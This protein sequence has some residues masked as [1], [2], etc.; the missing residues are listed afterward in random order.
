MSEQL[1]CPCESIQH[2]WLTANPPGREYISYRPGDFVTFRHA[3]LR[4]RAGEIQLA[5][6]V[7]TARSDLGLQMLEWWAYIADVLTF[8]T[9]TQAN[10]F[11]LGTAD[12]EASVRGLIRLLGHRPRPGIGAKVMLAALSSNTRPFV[13][14]AGFQ[15][16][17]KPGPGKQPQVFELDADAP[18]DPTDAVQ[19]DAD[20]NGELFQGTNI[21]LQGS[22]SGLAVGERL[23]LLPRNWQTTTTGAATVTVGS[24][25][26]VKDACGRTKTRITL[27]ALPAATDVP[28]DSSAASYRLL[29]SYA[30]SGLWTYAANANAV[31]DATVCHLASLA[32]NIRASDPMFFD[33]PNFSHIRKVTEVEEQVWYANAAAATPGNPPSSPPVP[34]P[35][36]HTKLTFAPSV[37]ANA[38]QSARNSVQVHFDWRDVGDLV[39]A[40]TETPPISMPSIDALA[41]GNDLFPVMNKDVLIED[42]T[43]I[44]VKARG[45]V[46]DASREVIRLSAFSPT[47]PALQEPLRV[48]FNTL[49]L[50]CGKTVANEVLGS[51]DASIAGQ[52]FV[53]QKSPLTYLPDTDSPS[54]QGYR[55]TLRIWVDELEWTEAP[56]FYEQPASA[57]IFVTFEDEDAKTHVLFGD[58]INGA[59]L[60]TGRDNVVASYRFG[61]GHDAPEHGSLSVVLKPYPGLKSVRN[62]TRPSG[63][64]DPEPATRIAYYGPRSTLT[65]GRAISADDCTAIALETPGVTGARAYAVWDSA[66]QRALTTIY[67]AE[68]DAAREAVA[69]A[70]RKAMD[71]NRALDV[72]VA[73]PRRLSLSLTI[74]PAPDRK[75]AAVEDSVRHALLDPDSGLLA[76]GPSRIGRRLYESEIYRAC[77]AVPGVVAVHGLSIAVDGVAPSHPWSD[78][79]VGRFH[80]LVNDDLGIDVEARVAP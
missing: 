5:R 4:G 23:M 9:E 54:A 33:A 12:L 79:G 24:V 69:A 29:R 28:T 6:W 19:V 2:P 47:P 53:L 56:S 44:G 41:M 39:G 31:I 63:G 34:I 70:L 20:S 25:G 51:G 75:A 14:P 77:I 66:Q 57:R 59:R 68:G 71:P 1:I 17:S 65:F 10:E 74:V 16:Q 8:Y 18:I 64:E 73:S 76:N 21:Y 78:P 72:L 15:V 49:V 43:G 60:P 48:L 26:E 37:G 58:S 36:L 3:L 35:I 38:A 27:S 11:F 50:T 55:S 32:R 52:E 13:L 30:S 46:G 40:P 62:P 7:P 22:V 80:D 45:V 67:V 42:R 61:S